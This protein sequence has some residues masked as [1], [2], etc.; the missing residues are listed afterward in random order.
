[1]TQH[2]HRNVS[3]ALPHLADH[4]LGAGVEVGSRQG[5]RTIEALHQHVILTSPLEREVITPGRRASLPAQ[6]AETVW[7]LSGRNDIDWLIP[8]LP[9]ARDFSDDGSTWRGGYGPR[10]RAWATHDEGDVIDQVARVVDL[11]RADRSTRRALISIYDPAV[12]SAD[13]RDIPC[14]NWLS[15]QSRLGYLDLHVAARSNDLVWG[16]SGINAFEWS[17]LLEIVAGLLGL[18]VGEIHFTL[19]S[20]HVYD[21]HWKRASALASLAASSTSIEAAWDGFKPSPRFSGAAIDF[22]IDGLDALL[23]DW[24]TLEASIRAGRY[25]REEIET[26]REPMLRSWLH[27]IAWWWSNDE[28]WLEPYCGTALYAAAKETPSV[29]PVPPCE[30]EKMIDTSEPAG[31][32]DLV[33]DRPAPGEAFVRFASDLHADKSKAY[34]DS[35]KKRGEMLGIMANIARKIDRLGVAGG[36]DTSA[37]TAI[38]LLIYLAKY[39]L[40]LEEAADHPGLN[41]VGRVEGLLRY[42]SEHPLEIALTTD[43]RI[44]RLRN[45]FDGLEAAVTGAPEDRIEVVNS[46][47]PEAYELAEYLWHTEGAQ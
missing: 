12:D 16:W 5:D 8:Y 38:D 34:G 24:T 27:V 23:D 44:Y 13:G 43:Q 46:M 32:A 42:Y 25:P 20:L 11:L 22:S 15:F 7:I 31:P 17:T 18:N 6:I 28:S 47:L 26:F 4:L 10:I 14:N 3:T 36:G 2:R 45:Y 30:P 29:R 39:R 41:E 37:D 21:R 40:W 33:N 35:W 1:M 9:R 19:S